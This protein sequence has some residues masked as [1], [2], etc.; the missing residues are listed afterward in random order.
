MRTFSSLVVLTLAPSIFLLAQ[1]QEPHGKSQSEIRERVLQIVNRATPKPQR[2]ATGV[3]YVTPKP[4]LSQNDYDEIASM[5]PL[6]IGPLLE[7]I[8]SVDPMQ[9]RVA[10]RLLG[11]IEN[12]GAAEALFRYATEPPLSVT[13]IAAISFLSTRK[14]PRVIAKLQAIS[15]SD[16]DAEVRHEAKR[17]LDEMKSGKNATSATVSQ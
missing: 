4:L 12:D 8:N 14:G 11:A 10:I 15:Q 2:L 6:A 5:G 16:R 17:R 13:R 3:T 9:Q 1:V 7:F